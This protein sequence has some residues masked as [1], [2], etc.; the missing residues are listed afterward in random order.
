M[1]WQPIETAPKD[2]TKVLLFPWGGEVRI[3]SYDPRSLEWRVIRSETAYPSHWMPLPAPPD[4]LHL[5]VVERGQPLPH[6]GPWMPMPSEWADAANL[7]RGLCES[8]ARKWDGVHQSTADHWH[9]VALRLGSIYLTQDHI[10][11]VERSAP[12]PRLS[13]DVLQAIDD[14][15]VAWSPDSGSFSV[16]EC[17]DR[18]QKVINAA[19]EAGRRVERSAPRDEPPS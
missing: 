13:D 11:V 14:L 18:L 10:S 2:G 5:S 17:E 1:T 19:F 4:P 15:R 7:A 3:G 9:S 6:D 8:E 12:T 16:A